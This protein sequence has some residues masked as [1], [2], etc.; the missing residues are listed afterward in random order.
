M[1]NIRADLIAYLAANSVTAVYTAP[2]SP[3]VAMPYYVLTLVSCVFNNDSLTET[4]GGDE[5][6]QVDVYAKTTAD[7]ETLK[8]ALLLAVDQAGKYPVVGVSAVS[9]MRIENFSDNTE[10]ENE[11]SEELI[12]RYTI[13]LRII[14]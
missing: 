9:S 7:A 6:W 11:G 10:L 14:K 5:L 4:S 13:E 1:R 3:V 12:I 8:D 2:V